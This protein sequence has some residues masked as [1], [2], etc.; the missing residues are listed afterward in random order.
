MSKRLR[1][2]EEKSGTRT[3]PNLETIPAEKLLHHVKK[4]ELLA[5]VGIKPYD[6]M[7]TALKAQLGRNTRK[8]K[9]RGPTIMHSLL[10]FVQHSLVLQHFSVMLLL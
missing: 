4:D 7:E 8:L 9:R 5:F 2:D 6:D 10:P 3:P 1:I